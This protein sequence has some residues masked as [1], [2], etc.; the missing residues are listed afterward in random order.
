MV[1]L[2][3]HKHRQEIAELLEALLEQ[4]PTGTISVAWDN[5]GTHK[6]DELETVLRAAWRGLCAHPCSMNPP[7]L[8]RT[9][10]AAHLTLRVNSE[11]AE[12]TS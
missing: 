4:Y 5:A 7:E 3:Q 9:E 8:A 1:L 6:D 10:S 2:K 12:M 11:V